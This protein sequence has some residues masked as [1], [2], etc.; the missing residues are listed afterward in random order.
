MT[1]VA[2]TR[3]EVQDLLDYLIDKRLALFTNRVS[4]VDG[5][6]SWHGFNDGARLLA[7]RGLPRLE[8]YR[9]WV[10]SGAYSALLPDGALLQI[11]YDFEG[12]EL[13]AHRLAYVPCP[14]EVDPYLLQEE[15]VTDVI[16]MYASQH[17]AVEALVL[18]TTVRFDYDINQ[19]KPGH[20][21]AHLTLNASDCRLA[22]AGPLRLGHFISFVFRN[23][24]PQVWQE[25]ATR[26]RSL[27][28]AQ[29]CSP[30]ISDD[31]RVTPHLWWRDDPLHTSG[32]S[33]TLMSR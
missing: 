20:P 8:V 23:F 18:Q 27:S 14:F 30:T 7:H 24:Y 26:F 6:V 19:A 15:P 5:R 29:W 1:A 16:D 12:D 32:P 9:A 10:A 25:H 4:A 13:V 22:C 2:A 31:E 11:S 21:A 33:G 28:T 17:G 3:T